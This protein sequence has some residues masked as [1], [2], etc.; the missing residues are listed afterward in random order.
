M[1]ALARAQ[2]AS[3]PA[4]PRSR[5]GAASS[6]AR[7][8]RSPPG[9]RAAAAVPRERPEPPAR[10]PRRPLPPAHRDTARHRPGQPATT[11]IG[12]WRLRTTVTCPAS[13]GR[14]LR[15]EDAGDP[16]DGRLAPP[17]GAARVAGGRRASG[18]ERARGAHARADR[19]LRAARRAPQRRGAAAARGNAP[20]GAEHEHR[21][22]RGGEEGLGEPPANRRAHR[23]APAPTPAVA[24]RVPHCAVR[25]VAI[26]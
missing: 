22:D 5:A 4:D 7:L 8:P 26:A 14:P 11:T 2:H 6:G 10:R 12:A 21:Q 23:E 24:G 19:R 15:G 3:E 16:R 17:R 20:A 13:A 1:P 9:G 18:A 25:Q